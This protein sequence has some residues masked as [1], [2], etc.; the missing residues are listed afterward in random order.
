MLN[1]RQ[2]AE[3]V[4]MLGL[5]NAPPSRKTIRGWRDAGLPFMELGSHTIRYD[6]QKA[7]DWFQTRMTAV[8]IHDK[9]MHRAAEV[10]AS[11]MCRKAAHSAAQRIVR[12]DT[13]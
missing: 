10:F 11:R 5:T 6:P 7:W 3:W 13:A 2:F 1:C 8:G 4:V 12:Q 9:S